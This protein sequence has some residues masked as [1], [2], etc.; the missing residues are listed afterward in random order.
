MA[1]VGNP[2]AASVPVSSAAPGGVRRSGARRWRRWGCRPSRGAS[3]PRDCHR[4]SSRRMIPGGDDL[5]GGVGDGLAGDVDEGE[6]G[7]A[8][9]LHVRH[10]DPSVLRED[11]RGRAVDLVV[12]A[13]SV[14]DRPFLREH[15]ASVS[16]RVRPGWDRL[17]PAGAPNPDGPR[18]SVVT[19]RAP[20]P[21]LPG[22]TVLG[23]EPDALLVAGEVRVDTATPAKSRSEAPVPVEAAPRTLAGLPADDL[24]S[25]DA[26]LGLLGQ[27]ATMAPDPRQE[28]GAG[29]RE[30]PFPWRGKGSGR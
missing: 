26:V 23:G 19:R 13:L 9:H 16:W 1:R 18:W 2:R 8:A 17:P 15:G 4:P 6:L 3:S 27:A 11:A 25:G 5:E 12:M 14:E 21:G 10:A 24:E 29:V 22:R 7:A 20:R 30:M 28:W